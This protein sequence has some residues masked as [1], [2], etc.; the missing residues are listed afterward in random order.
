MH[1]Q[2]GG[3]P[4]SLGVLLGVNKLT[5]FWVSPAY[6]GLGELQGEGHED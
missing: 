3:S 2:W 4:F 1:L 5:F 6:C